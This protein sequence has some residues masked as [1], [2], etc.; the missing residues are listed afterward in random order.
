MLKSVKVNHRPGNKFVY[1]K[2]F[3]SRS[4]RIS[5]YRFYETDGE[6]DMR[7]IK[8]RSQLN[9]APNPADVSEIVIS[10]E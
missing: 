10:D 9:F 4:R 5:K 8:R 6:A 1:R 3:S 2:Y 7:Q